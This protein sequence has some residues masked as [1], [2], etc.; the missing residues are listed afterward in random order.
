MYLQQATAAPFQGTSEMSLHKFEEIKARQSQDRHRNNAARFQLFRALSDGRYRRGESLRLSNIAN[1][2]Q[3]DGNS[4]L[5]IFRDLQALGMVTLSGEHSAIVISS[6]PKEMHEAYEIRAALEEMGGRAAAQALKGNTDELQYEVDAMRVAVQN[7]DLDAYAE[8]DVIFHRKILEASESDVLLRVWDSLHFDIRVRA[9]IGKVT[10]DLPVVVEEH[11]PIVDHLER[12][13]G[14]EAGMLLRNHVETFLQLL[15]RSERISVFKRD[16]EVA[17]A[18][19]NASFPQ[20][21]PSIPGLSVHSFYKPAQTIGGDYYD[22]LS[23]QDGRWGIAV[24]DVSGKGISAAL[25]M[26]SLQASLRTRALHPQA[27]LSTLISDINRLVYKSSPV[28][29]F[30][31]LFYA[32]YEPATRT[33]RYV[34]AGHNPPF[35]VRLNSWWCDVFQLKSGGTPVGALEGAQYPVTTFQLG[36]GDVL[37]AYTDGITEAEK[38]DG[39][40]W[41]QQR[42]QRVLCSC[43]R[44]TPEK[45]IQCILDE[46]SAFTTGGSQKD[47]MTLVVVQVQEQQGLI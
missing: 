27:D 29:F 25:V 2:Y 18:V 47:D 17:K 41:G 35:V 12:G 8:H 39:E 38:T 5:R 19:Q 24:G 10:G 23:L 16:M 34:N 45:I 7:D 4:M 3:L 36:I 9:A 13:R 30:A 15:K 14:K 20:Q 33:L 21:S 22:F 43:G 6:D 26:A 32:E 42:L 11:Q 1:E 28:Q 40:M 31:S 44:Q 37:V 46:V